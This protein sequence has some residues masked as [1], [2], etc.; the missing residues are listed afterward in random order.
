MDEVSSFSATG[1]LPLGWHHLPPAHRKTAF[2]QAYSLVEGMA[3]NVYVEV[4]ATWKDSSSPAYVGRYAA[5]I[6]ER[7]KSG[8]GGLI[9]SRGV[10][11]REGSVVK[12]TLQDLREGKF[13][14]SEVG[15]PSGGRVTLREDYGPLL[16]F[17]VF[18]SYPTLH[19]VFLSIFRW[20]GRFNASH[21]EDLIIQGSKLT[22]ER[23]F[24]DDGF[25]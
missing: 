4:L 2:H 19:V 16:A 3:D 25:G 6:A 20:H 7:S 23:S 15:N 10:R 22:V 21:L 5:L 14:R 17:K 13:G 9:C 12:V 24:N 11:D 1:D 18:S 8:R